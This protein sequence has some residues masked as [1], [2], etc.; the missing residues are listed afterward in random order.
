MNL[1]RPLSVLFWFWELPSVYGEQKHCH[2]WLGTNDTQCGFYTTFW[3][4]LKELV[5]SSLWWPQEIF[6]VVVCSGAAPFQSSVKLQRILCL[7]CCGC[8]K[9]PVECSVLISQIP[10]KKVHIQ[11]VF[12]TADSPPPYRLS[13]VIL[14]CLA[15]YPTQAMKLFSGSCNS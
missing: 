14:F 9:F 4:L 10:K 2:V 13:V 3:A 11:L 5:N 7:Y 15:L 6:F 12:V 1:R 8:S